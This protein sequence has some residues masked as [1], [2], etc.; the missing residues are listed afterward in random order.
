MPVRELQDATALAGN[1]L[2]RMRAEVRKRFE[3]VFFFET[4]ELLNPLFHSAGF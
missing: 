4:G 3:R 2:D 1:A